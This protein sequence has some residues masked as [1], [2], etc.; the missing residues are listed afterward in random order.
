MKNLLPKIALFLSMLTL[1]HSCAVYHGDYSLKS[2]FESAKK[3]KVKSTY[4][5]FLL[6]DGNRYE[7]GRIND[8]HA[9]TLS[10]TKDPSKKSSEMLGSTSNA[11]P[12]IVLYEDA[13]FG[14]GNFEDR[15]SWIKLNN[16]EIVE[17]SK[18]KREEFKKLVYQ[19]GN[20]WGVTDENDNVNLALINEDQ[21]KKVS[22]HDP[23]LSVL[24]SI[25]ITPVVVVLIL[26]LPDDDY[27]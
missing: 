11:L 25:L 23:V 13:Y 15:G 10:K 6:Y 20:Y 4:N 7:Y 1:F 17:I 18:T 8:H 22:Q 26:Y 5:K 14:Y 12:H 21:V 2:A 19:K 27:Y 3:V 24:A 9:W 16:I